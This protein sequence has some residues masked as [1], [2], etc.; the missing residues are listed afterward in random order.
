MVDM[1]LIKKIL[2]KVMNLTKHNIYIWIHVNAWRPWLCW[3]DPLEPVG[4]YNWLK[5]SFRNTHK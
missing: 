4:V 2:Y 1:P 3:E 5:H